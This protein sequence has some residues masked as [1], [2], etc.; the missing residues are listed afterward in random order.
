[1]SR[2]KHKVKE[3]EAILKE[4]EGKG[5]RVTKGRNHYKIW[6]PCK[7]K[8]RKTVACTPSGSRYLTNLLHKLG[9]DTCWNE[10]MS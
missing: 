5:W 1:V 9:R 4:A 6:C 7:R 2:P 8:H 3:L 10:E